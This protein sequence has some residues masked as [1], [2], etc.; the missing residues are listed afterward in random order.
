MLGS[1]KGVPWLV[2]WLCGWFVECLVG[3]VNVW[4]S[5]G[6]FVDNRSVDV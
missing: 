1:T 2:D 3:W 5:A 6:W 4:L